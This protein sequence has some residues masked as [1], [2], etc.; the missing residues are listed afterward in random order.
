[1]S[2]P[3]WGPRSRRFMVR[4]RPKIRPRFLRRAASFHWVCR[5]PPVEN[6]SVRSVI[7][8]ASRNSKRPKL[9]ERWRAW[10]PAWRHVWPE[11][12]A[13]VANFG[14]LWW[15]P[16]TYLFHVFIEDRPRTLAEVA[17]MSKTTLSYFSHFDPWEAN[18]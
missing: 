1:M 6:E 3:L 11:I 10:I 16:T 17:Q 12:L 13:A 2:P 7:S 18:G 14:W 15:L 5:V 4:R 8:I 9:L